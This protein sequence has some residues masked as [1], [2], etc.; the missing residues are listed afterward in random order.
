MHCNQLK[1]NIIISLRCNK[2][3]KKIEKEDVEEEVE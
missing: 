1:N 3:M 2:D